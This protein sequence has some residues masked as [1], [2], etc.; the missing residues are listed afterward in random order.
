MKIRWNG[1]PICPHCGS[2]RENHYKILT[3]GE[4]KARYKCKD[5]RLPFSVTIGTIFEKSTIPLEKWFRAVYL[6]TINKKGISTR[7]LEKT[8]GVTQKTA[9]FMLSRLRNAVQ[10]KVE[11]EFEGINRWMKLMLL[12]RIKIVK[13]KKK[14]KNEN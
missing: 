6:F 3:R 2:Q 12:V 11:F 8:I 14:K 1:E 10:N 5:C 13:R 7:Q 4:D 9:W